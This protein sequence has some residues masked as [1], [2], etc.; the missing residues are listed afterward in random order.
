[1]KKNNLISGALVLVVA[2]VFCKFLGAVAKIPL[3][4]ILTAEGVGLYQLIFPLYTLLLVVS[5]SGIPVAI[6]KMVANSKSESKCKE[7]ISVAL[8]SMLKISV[9]C[10]IVLLVFSGVI[11]SMQ[12]NSQLWIC[13][14]IISPA[15]VFVSVVSVF[16]GYFQGKSNFKPTAISQ[17]VEQVVKVS[18]SLLLALYLSRFGIIESVIGAVVGISIS[19]FSAFIFLFVAYKKSRKKEPEILEKVS[20]IEI[21]QI[22]SELRT[23]TLTITLTSIILPLLAMLDSILYVNMLGMNGYSSQ[24]ATAFFGVESGMVGALLN[25]PIILSISLSSA[26]IPCLTIEDFEKRKDKVAEKC[27]IAFKFVLW[28]I[29]PCVVVFFLFSEPI[30]NFLFGSAL[31]SS[32]E[33][34]KF[35]VLLLS[36]TS[37]EMILI[38]F[39]QISIAVYQAK[40]MEKFPLK[41]MIVAGGVKLLTTILLLTIPKLCIYSISISTIVFYLIG[42]VCLYAKLKKDL[43]IKYDL[44]SEIYAP[45]ICSVFSGFVAISIYK[46]NSSTLIMFVALISFAICYVL[47]TIGLGFFKE[48]EFGY[49]KMFK[50][51]K[52]KNVNNE[53]KE[54]I[55]E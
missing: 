1:M 24:S 34:Q 21:K 52:L 18:V 29:L 31:H 25:L 53:V 37:F 15:I 47:S 20:E 35:A 16:R 45:I 48:S 6:S 23:N 26:I 10:L 3:N 2:S 14:V 43:K 28:F 8:K 46:I 42:Y 13:Y 12:G 36:L 50:F 32:G 41:I 39:M 27:K 19:E 49:F 44:F 9:M 33:L 40:N 5:S 30:L 22:K 51:K 17:I 7:I 38:S 54:I 55:Y 11:A 4:N